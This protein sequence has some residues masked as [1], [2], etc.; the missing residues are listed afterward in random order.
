M[1]YLLPQLLEECLTFLFRIVKSVFLSKIITKTSKGRHPVSVQ[2]CTSCLVLILLFFRELALSHRQA[3]IGCSLEHSHRRCILR[4][5]LCD[6]NTS[7]ASSNNSNLLALSRHSTLRPER[8]VVHLA[9]ERVQALPVREVALCGE[10][11]GIDEV[12]CVSGAT[13]LGLDV[14]LV[15]LEV[16]LS[17]YDARVESRVFL[18]L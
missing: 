12:L 2:L 10:A 4:R 15:C 16:E 8:G 13:V 6:L 3:K 5:L 18:D 14:P 17:T 9:L 7:R 1:T 11:D